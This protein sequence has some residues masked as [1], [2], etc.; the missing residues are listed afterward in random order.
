MGATATILHADLDAFCK[1]QGIDDTRAYNLSKEAVTVW[2]VARTEALI[3]KGVRVNSVSPGAV[4]T[5]I[6]G[7]F[8][9]AF[10]DK[11]GKMIGRVGR[12]A[13]PQEVAQ[14]IVFLA[15]PASAWLKGIDIPVDGGM[16]ALAASDMLGLDA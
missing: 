4:A 8:K 9:T 10:G 11:V 3:A 13:N 1:S 6:L 5:G 15:S 12:P 7:D 2:T 16:G 14:V